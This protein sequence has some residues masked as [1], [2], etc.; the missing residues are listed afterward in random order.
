MNLFIQQ[1]AV[2]ENGAERSGWGVFV[3]FVTVVIAGGF[4]FVI[5]SVGPKA[6]RCIRV[7][8]MTVFHPIL[9]DLAYTG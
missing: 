9:L 7:F 2:N 4:E 1:Y 3:W 6:L 5:G 8:G